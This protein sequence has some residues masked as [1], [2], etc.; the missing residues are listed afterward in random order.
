MSF[1]VPLSVVSWY[2]PR[3][4]AK[5]S[6]EPYYEYRNLVSDFLQALTTNKTHF[7]PHVR[8]FHSWQRSLHNR[9]GGLH[10]REGSFHAMNGSHTCKRIK[11]PYVDTTASPLERNHSFN[12][13]HPLLLKQK[14][15]NFFWGFC[16]LS[17]TIVATYIL[18]IFTIL[19]CS[20]CIASIT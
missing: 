3:V 13:I 14:P 2:G 12:V 7:H 5:R 8:G 16:F 1:I 11:E 17:I 6:H 19:R 10:A 20:P 18:M 9:I 15:Q 4:R